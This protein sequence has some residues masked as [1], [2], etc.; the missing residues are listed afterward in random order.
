M[1][2]KLFN[3]FVDLCLLRKAPQDLPASQSLFS[4]ILV[5]SVLTGAAG[6]SDVIP[7]LSALA[8]SAL[9]A[10]IALVLLRLA[11]TLKGYPNRFQQTA[12]AIFGI[13]I[14][15]GL[16]AMPMQLGISEETMQ[17]EMGGVI[18]LA[19]LVLLGWVQVVIGHILRHALSV[20]LPLGIGLALTYSVISGTVIQMLFLQTPTPA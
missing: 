14:I 9:D 19:Y 12:T 5:L 2:F 6:V 7:G 18:A 10:V 3:F 8:A 17:G 11:L 1:F 16:L 20:S 4:L 13:G 15:L